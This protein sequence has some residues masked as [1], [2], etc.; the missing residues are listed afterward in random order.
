MTR[1]FSLTLLSSLG[2][3][4]FVTFFFWLSSSLEK[5]IFMGFLVYVN[6]LIPTFIGTL[7]YF[8]IKRWRINKSKTVNIVIQIIMLTLFF[9][10][11]LFIWAT[12]DSLLFTTL[13]WD[14]IKKDFDSQFMGFL[15]ITLTIATLLPIFDLWLSKR[16][17]NIS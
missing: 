14:N 16:N 10:I 4:V 2:G 3:F 7:I 15:P 8:L 9:I 13:S 5:S 12:I 11:G 17:S 6:I 1:I